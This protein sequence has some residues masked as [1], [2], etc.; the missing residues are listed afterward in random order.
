MVFR[1]TSS[2]LTLKMASAQVVECKLPATVISLTPIITQ[3]T[4]FTQNILLLCS[5]HF[6]VYQE[7]SICKHLELSFNI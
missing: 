3:L 6:P 7:Y 4:I 2:H 1:K 5:N